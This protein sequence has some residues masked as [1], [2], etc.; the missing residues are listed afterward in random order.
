M[1]YTF[2]L[3]MEL[4]LDET[5]ITKLMRVFVNEVDARVNLFGR[6]WWCSSLVNWVTDC[7]VVTS[8]SPDKQ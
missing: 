2:E 3:T 6:I 4:L 1:I 7:D 8:S 5:D